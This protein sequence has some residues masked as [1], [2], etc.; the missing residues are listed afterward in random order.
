MRDP[1]SLSNIGVSSD[2]DG[3]CSDGARAFGADD[4]RFSRRA[5]LDDTY[6]SPEPDRQHSKASIQYCADLL[7]AVGA[8]EPITNPLMTRYAPTMKSK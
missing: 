4:N 7:R 2:G 1:A 5:G 3:G 8:W 6:Q